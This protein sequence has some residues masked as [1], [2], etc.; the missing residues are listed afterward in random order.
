MEENK[1]ELNLDDMEKISGGAQKTV[2]TRSAMVR[3]GAGSN[4]H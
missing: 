2:M 1:K 3:S 4:L